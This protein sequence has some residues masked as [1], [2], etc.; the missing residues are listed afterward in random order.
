MNITVD[1][2]LMKLTKEFRLIDTKKAFVTLGMGTVWAP[3]KE[4]DKTIGAAFHGPS[5][6]AVD[7]I[8][9]SDYGVTGESIAAELNGIQLYFGSSD[10]TGPSQ[11]V[12][13]DDLLE[14]GYP[15]SVSFCE[16][17]RTKIDGAPSRND[18]RFDIEGD[19]DILIGEDESRK[20]V[21]LV[22]KNNSTVFTHDKKVFVT[23][24]DGKSVFVQG[25]RISIGDSDGQTLIIDEDRLRGFEVLNRLG[26][27]IARTVSS[28]MRNIPKITRHI[29]EQM[30]A[31][32]WHQDFDI[33][34]S[35]DN[36]DEFDW[37]D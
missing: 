33:Y 32:R 21:M 28:V 23:D 2:R 36:V 25:S 20:K 27:T 5:R 14:L 3:L 17:V 31:T 12:T 4:S 15:S 7:A 11:P 34:G 1:D 26:P 22:V 8:V 35:Y 19:A 24:D 37:P 18:K 16:S 29:G 9:E 30:R 10:L 6:F 13:E